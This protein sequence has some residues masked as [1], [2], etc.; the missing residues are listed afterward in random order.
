[1]N[2]PLAGLLAMTVYFSC[3]TGGVTG[4]D[5]GE[6]QVDLQLVASGL[7]FPL[8][9]TA[10]PQDASRLFI[11]EKRGTI[12][13]IKN[14]VLQPGFFLDL[15]GRVTTG[16]EQGLLGMAF[17]PR[18]GRVVVDYTTSGPAPGGRSRIS[19]FT[20]SANPDVL[21]LASERVI[22]EVDQPYS[23]HNGGHVAFGPDGYLYIGLGDGGSGGDPQG[24]GQDRADL[25]GSILRIDIDH[26][27][28]YAIPP[29]NPYAGDPSKRHE[30]WNWGLRN[31]WR[32]S[33][34]RTLGNLYIADVGQSAR[35]EVDV[36]PASTGGGENYG[37]AI[38]EGRSCYRSAGCST[39]GLTLPVLEYTHA[40]GCSIT[41]GYVYRGNAIPGIQGQYFYSDYCDGWVR[42]FEYAG[43]TARNS[44]NWPT[45]APGGRISSFGE[46]ASGELYIVEAEGRVFK[47][48]PRE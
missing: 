20:A 22:L 33:F 7:S 25:L 19:T 30:I 41:G 44:R 2:F 43:G 45:L 4:P 21:D 16:S 12:R 48:V 47:L 46:D 36:Q 23:N 8:Y 11:V 32:F 34:D 6:A 10:P 5:P 1:M 17:H 35:E 26:A 31:P 3:S 24:H 29:T 37:W 42:S 13:M 28:P 18:D 39:V 27:P 38:M 14:G 15:R 9:V 40:D